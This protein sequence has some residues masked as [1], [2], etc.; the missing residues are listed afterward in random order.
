MKRTT[1]SW[2]TVLLLALV[3]LS[4]QG[5]L[6]FGGGPNGKQVGTGSNGQQVTVKQDVFKGKFYLTIGHNL[7]AIRGDGTSQELVNTGNVYDP[8]VSPDGKSIAFI[9]K[10][11]QYSDLCMVS[12]TGGQVQMLRTG[13][14]GGFYYN[15]PFVHNHYY[16]YAQPAW[17][18]DGSH[19]LFLSDLEK[20]NWYQQTGI[21]APMLDMQVF[22]IPINTPA[23][24]PQDVAYASFGDGGNRDES[25]RPGHPDEIV[26][27]HYA[28]DAATQTQQVIQLFLEN[29]N[30]IS[31]N[32]RRYYPGAPG[33]GFD[34]GIAITD[35]K[36][37]DLQPAFSPDGNTIAYV[38]RE[39]DGQMSLDVMPVPPDNI[40]QTPND[41][42]TEKLAVQTYQTQSS[43]LVSS[44]YV[45]QPVWSPDGK[46]LAYITYNGGGFDLWITNLSPNAKTGA[47]TTQGSPIQVTTGGVDGD[48]R[49]VWTS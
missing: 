39:S 26:Y 49:P 33:G 46:Q 19:L 11:K 34:P 31:Q 13:N 15:G 18:P 35:G 48:V 42:N 47:Y 21:D 8:A 37:Q 29:P 45:Q 20:E 23:V 16:W 10:S 22:S 41:P 38:Q 24:K 4:V 17:S 28:Y 32:P 1:F 40:T 30:T 3:A 43:H 7:Y 5:C 6:G 44:L 27:T 12:T 2:S 25:Y 9:E 36:T 14:L